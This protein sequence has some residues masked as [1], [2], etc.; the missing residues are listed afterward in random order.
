MNC[1]TRPRLLIAALA[2]TALAACDRPPAPESNAVEGAA[3]E[4]SIDAAETIYTNARVYTV[5]AD[6]AWAEAFAVRDGKFLAVG[7]AEAITAQHQ[8]EATQLVDLGGRMVMPGLHDMH[9]HLAQ[10]GTKELFECGF[11]FTLRLDEILEKVRECVA[12]APAGTWLRGGQWAMELLD[13]AEPPNKALLD[14]IAP[15][16]PVFLIDSTV[17]AAWANS[18]A[19]EMLGIGDD[20]PDPTGGV[21]VRDPETGEATGILLDNAAYEALQTLPA[22]SAQQMREALQWSVA[23]MNEVGVTALKDAMVD[24]GALAAYAALDRDAQLNA[25]LATSLAWRMAW[26][27]PQPKLEATIAGRASAASGNVQPDFI[28]IML[29]GIPPSQTAAVL[30]PY[31]PDGVHPQGHAGYLTQSP[32]SLA[33]DIVKLDAQGLTV[34]LHAAGDRAVRVALDAI[35]AARKANGDSGMRHE[36]SHAEMIHADDV[37]RFKALDVTA[38]MSPILWYPSPLHEAMEFALG[39]ER[40]DRFWPIKTLHET[41]ALVIYGSDWPSVVPS[42]NPWPGVE[43]MVTR[44]DPYGKN[45]GELGLDQALDLATVLRIFTI[46]GAESMY[47]AD[48]RGS[49]ETGK[50]ADFIVLDRNLFEIAPEEISDTQVLQTVFRGKTVHAAAQ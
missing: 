37:P 16:V 44:R 24:A 43:A 35:E 34:K 38:E 12:Q 30:E 23:Q 29:D 33:E 21:I 36:I 14:Q 18:K 48:T 40:A 13:S 25:H 39:L 26:A 22:Y 47:S 5:D 49:I 41:G 9:A 31:V 32:E 10:A 46:N 15:D 50:S 4:S 19:L 2:M 20:T 27:G 8:G 11:P 7:S 17:H 3:A 45:P 1:K 6:N 28:K 42:A